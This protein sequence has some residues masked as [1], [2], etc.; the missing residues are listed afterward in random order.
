[1]GKDARLHIRIEPALLE[2]AKK[3][4]KKKHMS[5]SSV[6]N[7]LLGAWVSE[8]SLKRGLQFE[9]AADATEPEQI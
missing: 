2:E 3:L 4:A 1:M 8:E 5:L 6:V 9:P 7:L